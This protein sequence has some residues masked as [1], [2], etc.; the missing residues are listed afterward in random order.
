MLF[1]KSC[2]CNTGPSLVDSKRDIVFLELKSTSQWMWAYGCN[3]QAQIQKTSCSLRGF[4]YDI[5]TSVIS[6]EAD[7]RVY[8]FDN[9]IDKDKKDKKEKWTQYGSLRDPCMYGRPI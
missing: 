8:I 6:K 1:I 3:I 5:Q 9:V 4:H 7:G 2:G